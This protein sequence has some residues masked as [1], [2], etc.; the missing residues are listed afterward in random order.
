VN[1]NKYELCRVNTIV[2]GKS[3][4]KHN[5]LMYKSSSHACFLYLKIPYALLNMKLM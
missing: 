3:K 5:A 2:K 1:E 4:E